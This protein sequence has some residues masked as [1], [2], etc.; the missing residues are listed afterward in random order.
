MGSELGLTKSLELFP[1]CA[2]GSL[3]GAMMTTVDEQLADSVTIV[4][5]TS[6][7]QQ[8]NP[9]GQQRSSI[10]MRDLPRSHAVMMPQPIYI[11]LFHC[12]IDVAAGQSVARFRTDG[13]FAMQYMERCGPRLAQ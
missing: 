11:S 13:G 1:A 2:A 10:K 4:N 9:G 6:T 5:R 12:Y 3:S 7:Q 8:P